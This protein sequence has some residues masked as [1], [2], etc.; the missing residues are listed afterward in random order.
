M[1]EI[2]NTHW[3]HVLKAACLFKKK[4]IQKFQYLIM[5]KLPP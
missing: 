4:F 5:K 3:E 2:D 1:I